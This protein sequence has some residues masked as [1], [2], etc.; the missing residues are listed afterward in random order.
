VLDEAS[1]VGQPIG[2]AQAEEVLAYQALHYLL[3]TRPNR[4]LLHDREQHV[5]LAA[6]RDGSSLSFLLMDLDRFKENSAAFGHACGDVL[7]LAARLQGILRES[8]TVA[9]LGGDE[10]G[11]LLPATIAMGATWVADKLLMADLTR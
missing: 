6:R 1:A 4:P 11:L 8:D 10:F 9:R 3:T 5:I 2:R 7:Q